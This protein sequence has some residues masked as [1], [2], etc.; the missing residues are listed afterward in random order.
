[1]MWVMICES[2]VVIA[3]RGPKSLLSLMCLYICCRLVHTPN[4]EICVCGHSVINDENEAKSRHFYSVWDLNQK[5]CIQEI[6]V[7]EAQADF[8]GK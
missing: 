1:M 8:Y 6:S 7:E 2:F 3:S 5:T 4:G